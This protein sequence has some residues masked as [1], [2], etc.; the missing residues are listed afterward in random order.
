MVG[1]A[2]LPIGTGRHE[3]L[4]LEG[5]GEGVACHI[6]ALAGN[7]LNGKLGGFQQAASLVEPAL[8]NVVMGRH[9]QV[10]FK[11]QCQVAAVQAQIISQIVFNMPTMPRVETKLLS[12]SLPVSTWVLS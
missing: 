3:Q 8:H 12:V 6:A 5:F 2:I 10:I 11:Q 7:I 9:I 1:L 4:L